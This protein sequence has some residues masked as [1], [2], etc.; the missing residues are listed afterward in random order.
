[1][2]SDSKMSIIST[3]STDTEDKDNM[4]DEWTD[5]E[6]LLSNVASYKD[7]PLADAD[8]TESKDK[9]NMED[10]E[11]DDEVHLS[12]VTPYQDKPLAEAD[13]TEGEYEGS[14]S[15]LVETSRRS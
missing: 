3:S 8:Q 2:S 14:G 7:E 15:T 6:V 10:E 5:D 11:S 12:N 13:Q 9:D 4:E 1:M